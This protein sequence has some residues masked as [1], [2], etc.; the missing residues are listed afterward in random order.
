MK[1]QKERGNTTLLGLMRLKW[2]KRSLKSTRKSDST[3]MTLCA[4]LIDT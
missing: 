2:L 1:S 4:A 3:L